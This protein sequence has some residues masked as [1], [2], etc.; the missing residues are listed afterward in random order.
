M[1]CSE[2]VKEWWKSWRRKFRIF[3]FVAIVEGLQCS[4]IDA[5]EWT[6]HTVYLFGNKYEADSNEKWFVCAIGNEEQALNGYCR[7][8]FLF[9]LKV[10]ITPF[11]LPGKAAQAHCCLVNTLVKWNTSFPWSGWFWDGNLWHYEDRC[12]CWYKSTWVYMAIYDHETSHSR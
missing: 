10:K 2:K 9:I 3:I 4:N 7:F 11:V 8:I 1:I 12:C 6:P 5:N